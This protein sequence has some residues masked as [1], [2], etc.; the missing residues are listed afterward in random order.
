LSGLI[1]G[2][3]DHLTSYNV[4]AEAFTQCGA[5]GEVYGLPRHLFDERVEE[6]ADRR[7]SWSRRSKTP[8]SAVASCT[9]AWTALPTTMPRATDEIRRAF[10]DCC[11]IHAARPS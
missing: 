2:G 11:G 3:S 9:A 6:W 10:A 4:Y 5:V 7:E 8:R 1:V